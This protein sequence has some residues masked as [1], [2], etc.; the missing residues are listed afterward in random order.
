MPKTKN[1]AC[2]VWVPAEHIDW[3]LQLWAFEIQW[4][5]AGLIGR[6]ELEL[7]RKKCQRPSQSWQWLVCFHNWSKFNATGGQTHRDTDWPGSLSEEL[8]LILLSPLVQS[9]ALLVSIQQANPTKILSTHL[10]YLL[11]IKFTY[12]EAKTEIFQYNRKKWLRFSLFAVYWII[13]SHV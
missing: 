13:L 7:A 1:H 12:T 4:K 8:D 11:Y 9:V 2:L 5:L 3:C 6:E 10:L